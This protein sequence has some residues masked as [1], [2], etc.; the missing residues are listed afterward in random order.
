MITSLT[1]LALLAN[2]G[3]TNFPN[4]TLDLWVAIFALLA[5]GATVFA[6]LELHTM[7]GYFKRTTVPMGLIMPAIID[8]GLSVV[9]VINFIL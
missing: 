1:V 8:I 3:H 7:R 6:L 4:S 5:M 2:Y 9:L